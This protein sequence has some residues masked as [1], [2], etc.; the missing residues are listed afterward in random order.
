[1]KRIKCVVW[2]LD[3]TLWE[4][5]LTEGG[6]KTL[7]PGVQNLIQTLDARGIL[8][9]IA[10]KN[11]PAPA[12]AR[13]REFELED[14]FLCPQISW[15]PK[16]EGIS[17]IAKT[18]NLKLEAFALVDDN[19]FERDEV[20]FALPA[21]TTYDAL[22]VETLAQR[23]ELQVR[24]L[25]EDAR[26]RRQMYQADL[27][28]NAAG[29]DFPGSNEAFLQTLHMRMTLAPV[30]EA[31]LRRVEELTLRTHQLNSTG[32]TYSYEELLALIDSP[33]HLFYICGLT[34]DY[35]D[36]G[37][38]GLLLMERGAKC[39][40]VRLLIVSCRVMSRG[41]GTALL[42][43]ATQIAARMGLPLRA[44]FLETEFNRI[45]YI[46]YKLAG[47]VEVEEPEEGPVTLGYDETEP[48]PFP[49][50]LTVSWEE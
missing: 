18:L 41:I 21:V 43:A 1:M 37:K 50:Y 3:N 11:D 34:D 25:T 48:A 30:T 14:Y 7:R 17:A 9:S 32:C 39:L 40:T 26:N 49:P 20:A 29:A 38:V 13:L 16:S 2:D 12:M 28:R 10:S 6:G 27:R 15:G 31:D 33:D 19:P 24:F 8:Q 35:G 42:A 23:P 47:F 4:G 5:V 44:D 22:E 46:T 45:M 36:S